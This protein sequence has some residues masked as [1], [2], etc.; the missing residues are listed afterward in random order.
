MMHI[1]LIDCV[2]IYII[3]RGVEYLNVTCGEHNNNVLHTWMECAFQRSRIKIE[4]VSVCKQEGTK[5]CG[6]YVLAKLMLLHYI[7]GNCLS[8]RSIRNVTSSQVSPLL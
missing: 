5:D 8:L 2:C 7:K 1:I 4:I 3:M 6:L